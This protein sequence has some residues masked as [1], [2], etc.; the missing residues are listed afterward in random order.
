M[1][2]RGFYNIKGSPQKDK[3]GKNQT[4]KHYAVGL[5]LNLSSES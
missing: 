1:K 3:K 5:N 2:P 4:K